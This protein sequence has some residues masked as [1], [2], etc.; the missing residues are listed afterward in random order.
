MH[1]P[2]IPTGIIAE[3]FKSEAL[4]A[5]NEEVREAYKVEEKR[6]AAPKY[7]ND[8]SFGAKLQ[9]SPLTLNP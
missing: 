3:G 6:V 7:L 4:K 2:Q 5:R 8:N 1:M 9:V